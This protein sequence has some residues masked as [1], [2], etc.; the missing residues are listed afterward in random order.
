MDECMM[1]NY[2]RGSPVAMVS[3]VERSDRGLATLPVLPLPLLLFIP[4]LLLL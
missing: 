2:E 1:I 4:P 3:K